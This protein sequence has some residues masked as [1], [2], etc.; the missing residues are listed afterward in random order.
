MPFAPC[1]PSRLEARALPNGTAVLR[2]SRRGTPAWEEDMKR[3]RRRIAEG[4]LALASAV[5]LG[6]E[7]PVAS[8]RARPQAAV[9]VAADRLPD[10]AMA[11][12][13]GLSI[14]WSNGH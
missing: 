2:P 5:A 8:D 13:S 9:A 3:N 4:L 14:G 12:L 11:K 1:R 10:L 6:C 7:N